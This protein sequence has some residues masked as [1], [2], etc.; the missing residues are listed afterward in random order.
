MLK[1]M[2]LQTDG[3]NFAPNQFVIF[4]NEGR[5]FQSYTSMIAFVPKDGGK[6]QLGSDYDYSRTT[7]K[8][9]CR[10]LRV[11]SINDVRDMLNT[12]RA[13]RADLDE[14][15]FIKEKEND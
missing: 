4:T 11:D 7:M 14:I 8:Y 13:V 10:F 12:S 6:I 9:L 2:N 15:K 5:W 1:I 3:G